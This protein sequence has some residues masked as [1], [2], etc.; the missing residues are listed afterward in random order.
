MITVMSRALW[1]VVLLLVGC[2]TRAPPPPNET[3]HSAPALAS[4]EPPPVVDVSTDAPSGWQRYEARGWKIYLPPQWDLRDSLIQDSPDGT[5]AAVLEE[6]FG[7]PAAAFVS[8]AKSPKTTCVVHN[9]P[10]WL[11]TMRLRS[12]EGLPRIA[13]VMVTSDENA[14]NAAVVVTCFGPPGED[15]VSPLCQ[16]I[17]GTLQR[18]H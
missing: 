9:Q 4:P 15:T 3:P 6:Q 10:C 5:V 14:G 8:R 2:G 13:L 11:I 7:E 1:L 17:V 12:S 18:T 16:L